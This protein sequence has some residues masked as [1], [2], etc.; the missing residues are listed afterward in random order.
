ME[1]ALWITL[2]G[3]GLVFAVIVLLW[4]LMA[5]LVRIAREPERSARAPLGDAE[6]AEPID[7]VE[8]A[9]LLDRKRR[10]AAAGYM[11]ALSIRKV[12]GAAKNPVLVSAWQ[13]AQ[14]TSQISRPVGAPR[15]KVSR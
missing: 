13:V 5:L 1:N 9:R 2:V 15:K 11:A 4:G 6:A 12:K 14:R 10:A 3:M 8:Q 7:P